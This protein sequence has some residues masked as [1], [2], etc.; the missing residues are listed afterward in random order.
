MR[1]DYEDDATMRDAAVSKDSLSALQVTQL[2]HV[3]RLMAE[4]HMQFMNL[5]AG[6]FPFDSTVL[7]HL[8]L[9]QSASAPACTIAAMHQVP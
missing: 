5:L 1:A 7:V 2:K 3:T 4:I 9:G 8:V 6:M